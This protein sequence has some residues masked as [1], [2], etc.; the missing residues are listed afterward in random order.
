ML[1][2]LGAGVKVNSGA[3]W[4]SLC[5]LQR[6]KWFPQYLFFLSHYFLSLSFFCFVFFFVVMFCVL[7]SLNLWRGSIGW[8]WLVKDFFFTSLTTQYSPFFLRKNKI[9]Y[10]YFLF[11][12]QIKISYQESMLRIKIFSPLPSH[13]PSHQSHEDQGTALW[14]VPLR[15]FIFYRQRNC[16]WHH[17]KCIPTSL[18]HI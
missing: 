18:H 1:N 5:K 2:W 8:C 4:Y 14:E 10:R 6:V 17:W 16:K 12:L 7:N 15:T 11:L 3:Q 9:P 13:L